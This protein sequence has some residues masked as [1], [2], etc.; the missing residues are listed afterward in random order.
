M[1]VHPLACLKE[2]MYSNKVMARKVIASAILLFACSQAFGVALLCKMPCC[3]EKKLPAMQTHEHSTEMPIHRHKHLP[4]A[5]AIR[6][7]EQ[8]CFATITCTVALKTP[9]PQILR[10]NVAPTSTP[11]ESVIQAH[12]L[13]NAPSAAGPPTVLES[14]SPLIPA[15]VTLRI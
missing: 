6:T 5:T 9:Q 10:D 3:P 1:K 8:S 7:P 11:H 14:G 4:A 13:L 15:T 2:R 12:L